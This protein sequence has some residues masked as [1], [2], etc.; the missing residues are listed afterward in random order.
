MQA[1]NV[2]LRTSPDE[3]GQDVRLS[4]DLEGGDDAGTYSG[5]SIPFPGAPEGSESF[6]LIA[7]RKGTLWLMVWDDPSDDRPS[8]EI[9]LNYLETRNT[10]R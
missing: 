10:S 8:Y 1:F 3:P 6:V 9:K 2:T 7:N 5:V 4:C